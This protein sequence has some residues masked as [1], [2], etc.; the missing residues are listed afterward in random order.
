MKQ[1]EGNMEHC[2]DAKRQSDVTM[3]QCE[4]TLEQ[5]DDNGAP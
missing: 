1:C 3:E 4:G 5:C 2:D